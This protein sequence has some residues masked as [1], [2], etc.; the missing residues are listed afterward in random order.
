MG[1]G[2]QAGNGRRCAALEVARV[3]PADQRT[4]DDIRIAVREVLANPNY[5]ERARQLQEQIR[6]LPGPDDAVGL[7]EQLAAGADR[8]VM[9]V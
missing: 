2:D 8:Q 7:L 3:L 5:R 4:P 9:P 1:G 6:A